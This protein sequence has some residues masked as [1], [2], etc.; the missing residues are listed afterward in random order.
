MSLL[1]YIVFQN[2]KLWLA[3]K[4]L[5]NGTP[6]KHLFVYVTY[7]LLHVVAF[8]YKQQALSFLKLFIVPFICL[9]LLLSVWKSKQCQCKQNEQKGQTV[10][11]KYLN[12]ILKKQ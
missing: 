1:C 11:G 8:S 5:C 9:L 2:K 3:T 6:S 4:E 10:Q 7:S 12:C